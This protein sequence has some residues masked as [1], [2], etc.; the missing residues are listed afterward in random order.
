VEGNARK[1]AVPRPRALSGGDA[2]RRSS[3]RQV[4]RVR[5]VSAG[6]MVEVAMCF[7]LDELTTT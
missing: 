2:R 6:S 4:S 7:V 5:L 3:F 1:G